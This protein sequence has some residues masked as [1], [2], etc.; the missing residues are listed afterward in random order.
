[1]F[2]DGDFCIDSKLQR[3]VE[4][5]YFCDRTLFRDKKSSPSIVSVHEVANSKFNIKIHVRELCSNSSI[6]PDTVLKCKFPFYYN[7]TSKFRSSSLDSLKQTTWA[8][9]LIQIF[10]K[11]DSNYPL[12]K[13]AFANL[14]QIG[15]QADLNNN[16]TEIKKW[17]ELLGLNFEAV[18]SLQD[19]P[20]KKND[21][22]EKDQK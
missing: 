18:S 13:S 17:I 14:I 6:L 4:V 15:S 8:L 19:S 22:S 12:L 9:K 3:E 20:S 7:I 11:S 1:M 2:Y 21:N 10:E 16:F 5:M